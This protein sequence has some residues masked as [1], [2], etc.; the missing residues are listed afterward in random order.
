MFNH[1]QQTICKIRFFP[2]NRLSQIRPNLHTRYKHL[3]NIIC[4]FVE[5]GR[6][7][8]KKGDIQFC[9]ASSFSI[10][11]RRSSPTG[12]T[13]T[14]IPLSLCKKRQPLCLVLLARLWAFEDI[15]HVAPVFLQRGFLVFLAPG[16]HTSQVY[17][18]SHHAGWFSPNTHH[19]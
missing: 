14:V 13:I 5:L 11:S 12:F 17:Y 15:I 19:L 7:L 1:I 4:I 16:G 10:S 6:Q 2:F 9:I 8:E 18:D 3:A